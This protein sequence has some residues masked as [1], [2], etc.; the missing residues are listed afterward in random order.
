MQ[1]F[2]QEKCKTPHIFLSE[3]IVFLVVSPTARRVCFFI[4]PLYNNA[5]KI[6]GKL[7][8]TCR[9]GV[10]RKTLR[11]LRPSSPHCEDKA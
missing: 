2:C 7:A 1:G 8:L 3:H 4:M 5:V 11:V 6:F 10:S 9:E